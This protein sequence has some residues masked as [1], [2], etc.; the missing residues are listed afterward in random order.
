MW[1]G[2]WAFRTLG[3]SSPISI[4]PPRVGRDVEPYSYGAVAAAFQ[5]TLPVWGG[6]QRVTCAKKAQVNFNPPSPCGEGRPLFSFFTPPVAISIHPPRVGRDLPQPD[7]LRLRHGISIHPPRVGRDLAS[8]LSICSPMRISIHPP[9]VGRDLPMLWGTRWM[10]SFQSTLP[11]WGG[12][13]H[14]SADFAQVFGFQ[15][16]LPVWGGTLLFSSLFQHPLISIHPPRVGRD[17]AL[18]IAPKRV[19][20]SIHPPRVGRDSKSSQKFFVNFCARR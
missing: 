9:R 5:S 19:A 7:F 11:V 20:I 15:S 18:V 8:A 10:I 13:S 14:P 3:W 16:T 17:P 6:T 4:H 2:T 12:T 1:G